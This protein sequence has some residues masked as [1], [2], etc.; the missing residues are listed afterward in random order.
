MRLTKANLK[1]IL[2]KGWCERKDLIVIFKVTER[3]LR[4]FAAKCEEEGAPIVVV[5][6]IYYWDRKM[7]NK[8]LK[9]RYKT[10]LSHLRVISRYNK[11]LKKQLQYDLF[12][13]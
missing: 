5:G 7:F 3:K 9:T 2:L 13:K 12:H 1:K 8:S 6:G 10:A 4:R 11:Q